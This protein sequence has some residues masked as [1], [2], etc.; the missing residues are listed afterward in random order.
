MIV[1]SQFSDTMLAE[2]LPFIDRTLQETQDQYPEVRPLVFDTRTSSRS[3]EQVTEYTG[4]GQ[5]V[6]SGEGEDLVT[7]APAKA[8]SKTYTMVKYRLGFQY[9]RE[10]LEDA[11][12]REISQQSRNLMRSAID[13]KET[14]AFNIFNNG[15]SDTGPDGVSLFDASHP[16]VKAGGVQTNIITAADLDVASLMDL[17][18]VFRQWETHS[19]IPARIVPRSLLIPSD[20]EFV[21]AEI[22]RGDMR[23][24]TPNHTINALTQRVGLPAFERILISEYLTDNDAWFV[25]ANP[26]DTGL[27]WYD[28]KPLAVTSWEEERSDSAV[29]AGRMRFDVGY[30]RYLGVAGSAGQ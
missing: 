5:F 3:L 17:L 21:A 18:T 6:F 23:S 30:E 1:R 11:K 16:K 25:L 13:T 8:F 2:A 29:V 7:D 12:H 15:F 14:L 20:L 10:S 19:G 24:D 4:L 26:K 22:L 9:S 27:A 28:R